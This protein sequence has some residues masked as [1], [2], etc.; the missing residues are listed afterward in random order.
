M[1]VGG[2]KL[3]FGQREKVCRQP[4]WLSGRPGLWINRGSLLELG[5]EKE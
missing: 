2:L 3:G 1:R 4:T 5:A